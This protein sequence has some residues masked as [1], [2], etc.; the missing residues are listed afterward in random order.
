MSS[1]H[2]PEGPPEARGIE[3]FTS[4]AGKEA[5]RAPQTPYEVAQTCKQL[6]EGLGLSPAEIA[7]QLGI[8]EQ[9]V[10]NLLFLMSAPSAVRELVAT[11]KLSA[12]LAIKVL[13]E[14][15]PEAVQIL[16][17]GLKNA[18]EQQK[19]RITQKLLSAHARPGTGHASEATPRVSKKVLK[20]SVGWLRERMLEN[21]KQL[22]EFLAFL[23]GTDAKEV[24][25][26]F[27]EKPAKKAKG[28]KKR[29]RAGDKAGDANPA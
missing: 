14:H 20:A 6:E 23:S 12:T 13:R 16:Q 15:G 29:L 27:E 25:A 7:N 11:G 5:L 28:K 24:Q 19:D 10:R 4:A 26:L 3:V 9:H 21:D 18:G 8:T 1:G 22:L 2:H 17:D